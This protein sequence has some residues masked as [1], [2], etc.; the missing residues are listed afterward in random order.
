MKKSLKT[1]FAIVLILSIWII[2]GSIKYNN[3]NESSLVIQFG[4][5][6]KTTA[7]VPDDKKDLKRG[8]DDVTYERV[9]LTIPVIQSTTKVYTGVNLYD[10]KP[11]NVITQDKKTMVA[12]CYTTWQVD[13]VTKFYKT[14]SNEVIAQSRLD[15][16]VYNSLKNVISSL[17]QDVV[18]QGKDGSLGE[19]IQ[20]KVK[21]NQFGILVTDLEV[22]ALDL[23]E[24]NRGAVYERMKLERQA[25]SEKYRAEGEQYFTVETSKIDTQARKIVSDAEAEAAKK[26]AEGESEYY[27]ILSDAYSSSE[28]RKDF[29]Q[30]MMGIEAVKEAMT[31][32]GIIT[33]D[34]NSPIY[35]VMIDEMTNKVE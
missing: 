23:P 34:K 2:G 21:T 26:I 16:S 19:K 9:F 12:D 10:I 35:S 28:E 29:Y 20:E 4:K 11:T 13:D 14:V 32:G 27:K 17:N 6:V 31:N 24:V 5:I 18:I 22:K 33:I 25:I 3:M 7:N 1:I 15:V 30:Y 8:D